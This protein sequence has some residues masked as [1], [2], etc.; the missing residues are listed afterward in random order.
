MEMKIKKHQ[1]LL[2]H[3]LVWAVLLLS[4]LMTRNG[5]RITLSE[6]IFSLTGLLVLFLL[7]Y[8][9]YFILAPKLFMVK[10]KR[11]RFFIIN[12]VLVVTL[13]IGQQY[14][15]RY[16]WQNLDPNRTERK[17]EQRRGGPSRLTFILRDMLNMSLA[18]ATA[19]AIVMSKRWSKIEK[20]QQEAESAR[21]EAE[22]KN[23]RSQINPH[24]LLNTLNNIYALTAFDSDKAQEA[25][26]EL[27]QLMRHVLY[28]NQ[29]EYV[30]ISDEVAFI[31]SYVKLMKIR[32]PANV[33]VTENIDIDRHP[34]KKIAPLIFISLIENAFKHGISPTEESFI[35]I[36][37]AANDDDI[38]CRIENSNHPKTDRDRSGHGIGLTQVERRL[39]LAYP[40][41]YSW[42]KGESDDG[43]TYVSTITVKC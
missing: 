23:L 22:L 34:D 43:K 26:M 9:N 30:T 16:Y 15:M 11:T 40:E 8:L 36:N 35:N 38:R 29:Q 37:I 39:E 25:I 1:E 18:T 7:F 10:G 13:A 5:V 27:S 41:Q 12:A 2:I 4:P 19:A 21:V 24:F 17:A 6:Y 3:I 31:E 14:W 42:E 33:T 32:M 28:D 20:E